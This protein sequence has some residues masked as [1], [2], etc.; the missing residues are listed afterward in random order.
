MIRS[1]EAAKSHPAPAV[2]VRER[3]GN[4]VVSAELPGLNKDDVKVEVTGDGLVIQG[5]RK[6]EQEEERGGVHRSERSY[7]S[8]YRSIP[9]PEG[10]NIEQAKAQFNNG[11]L[12]HSRRPVRS[13]SKRVTSVSLSARK[14]A[15]KLQKRPELL[16]NRKEGRSRDLPSICRIRLHLSVSPNSRR[17]CKARFAT[18]LSSRVARRFELDR[19]HGMVFGMAT[20]KITITLQDSQL[21]EIRA[22]V[23]ARK[24]TSVSAFVKHA[25]GVA[26][27]DAAGWR[28]MLQD[29]LQQTGGPLTN[30]ERSWADA[31]LSPQG[32]KRGTRKGKA[33]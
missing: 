28:E 10:A 8:F 13:P 6:R 27:Y 22:L 5:E 15:S 7:G 14:R 18:S 1:S 25:V 33:A 29:A 30:K 19:L 23:A 24:A 3:D 16:V 31:L 21:E 32:Q 2:E 20:T 4:L 9:L 26:L 12:V 11:V 17:A